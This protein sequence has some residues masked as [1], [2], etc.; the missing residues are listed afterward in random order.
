MWVMRLGLRSDERLQIA[1]GISTMTNHQAVF[2]AHPDWFAV[3]GG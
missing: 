2:D 3:Y 1:H